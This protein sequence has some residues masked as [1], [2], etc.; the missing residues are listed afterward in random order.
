MLY[1]PHV[2]LICFYINPELTERCANILA[3]AFISLLH[4]ITPLLSLS[5]TPHQPKPS[6]FMALAV[7][8]LCG[9]SPVI[10]VSMAVSTF[11]ILNESTLR[12]M[13]LRDLP[14]VMGSNEATVEP[15]A[16]QGSGLTQINKCK[17][18]FLFL[19]L[20]SVI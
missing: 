11:H 18:W 14:G 6:V 10:T 2:N 17:K 4:S 15:V 1:K 19:V 7:N 3:P 13:N 12:Q 8:H 9:G 5:A 16:E 20:S